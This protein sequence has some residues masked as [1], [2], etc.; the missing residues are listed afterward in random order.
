V[1][2]VEAKWIL[3]LVETLASALVAAVG[4]PAIRLQQN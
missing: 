2:A 1:A 3:K 4:K